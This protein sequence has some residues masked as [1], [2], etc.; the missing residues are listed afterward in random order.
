VQDRGKGQLVEFAFGVVV[1]ESSSF[2][3]YCLE[4]GQIGY[5]LGGESAGVL[6]LLFHDG[7]GLEEVELFLGLPEFLLEFLLP[8][9]LDAELFLDEFGGLFQ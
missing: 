1:P 2:C 6:F 9:T 3:D 4:D 7:L 8:A 5:V